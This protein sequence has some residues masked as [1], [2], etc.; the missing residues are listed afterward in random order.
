MV[1]LGTHRHTRHIYQLKTDNINFIEILVT[2]NDN[3]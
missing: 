1:I 2:T 3:G